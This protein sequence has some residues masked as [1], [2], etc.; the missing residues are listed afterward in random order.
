I[1]RLQRFWNALKQARAT[2]FLDS[3]I[4]RFGYA[5]ERH[6]PEDRLMDLMISAESLFLSDIGSTSEMS[7]RLA[8]RFAHFAGLEGYSKKDAF[9]FMRNA[10][11]ARS[12]IVHGGTLDG[13]KLKLLNGDPASLPRFVDEVESE[14]RSTLHKAIINGVHDWDSLIFQ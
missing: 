9:R 8:L 11:D 13:N 12:S 7:Y 10:Y 5:G 3:A 14:L 6:R 2:P 1:E 4:R